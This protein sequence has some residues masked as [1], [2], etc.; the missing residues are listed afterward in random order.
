MTARTARPAL[1]ALCAL[2]LLAAALVPLPARAAEVAGGVV[3]EYT[4]QTWL[5]EVSAS[6]P[7]Q[8]EFSGASADAAV[9]AV[10]DGSVRLEAM[11]GGELAFRLEPDEGAS[12]ASV[13]IGGADA[14]GMLGADGELVVPAEDA[15]GGLEVS[16]AVV[17]AADGAG[18]GAPAETLGGTLGKLVQTG[19]LPWARALALALAASG[20][21]GAAQ[22][23]RARRGGGLRASDA[24][25]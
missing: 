2:C 23:A 25:E 12:V 16:F 22:A 17:T 14:S 1:A 8:V 10:R 4:P 18:G 11:A 7:G 15:H 20:A 19:D 6:G 3:V 21:V 24:L 9:T 5:F 13:R